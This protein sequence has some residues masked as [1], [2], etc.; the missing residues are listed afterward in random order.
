LCLFH[1]ENRAETTAGKLWSAE[2]SVV[3]DTSDRLGAPA[4]LI[5]ESALPSAGRNRPRKYR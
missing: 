4:N 3:F 2:T 5:A 1:G